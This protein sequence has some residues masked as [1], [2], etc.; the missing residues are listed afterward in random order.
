MKYYR[1]ELL[2]R[3]GEYENS[4]NVMITLSDDINPE[5]EAHTI[6]KENR[7]SDDDDFDEM[8]GGCYWFGDGVTFIPELIEIT[9]AQY[10][11]ISAANRILSGQS[12]FI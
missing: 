10:D 4:H 12:S 7:G 6:A 3:M 11:Q 8:G 5:D 1:Y 2:E 9:Q